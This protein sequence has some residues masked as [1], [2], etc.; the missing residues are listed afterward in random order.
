MQRLA[1]AREHLDGDLTDDRVLEGNL[2]DLRRINRLSGGF[3]LSRKALESLA[4]ASDLPPDQ[5]ASLLDVGTGGADIP[6]GLIEDWRRRGRRLTVLGIDNRAEVLAAA[7]RERPAMLTTEGLSL[8]V[9]DGRTLPFEDGSFDF[10]HA[11]LVLH[12]L[13]PTDAAALIREMAR[14]ARDGIVINDLARGRLRYVGAWVLLHVATRNE[15]TRHDGPLS[16]RRAYSLPEAR[17]LA[18]EA[19]LR[20]V[21]E[22]IG[23]VG[24]RWALAAVRG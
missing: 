14:V 24:H 20:I 19:G 3:E 12:H 21:H 4:V 6:V 9:A 18:T 16:V 15:F 17:A 8:R 11:S 5:P 1:G 10:A 23:F 7:G 13:E 2:R 22:E